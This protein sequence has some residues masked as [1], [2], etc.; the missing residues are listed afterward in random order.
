MENLEKLV[1]QAEE[2][3]YDTLESEY[4]GYDVFTDQKWVPVGSADMLSAAIEEAYIVIGDEET[5]SAVITAAYEALEAAINEFKAKMKDGLLPPGQSFNPVPVSGTVSGIPSSGTIKIYAEQAKTTLVKEVEVGWTVISHEFSTMEATVATNWTAQVPGQYTGQ[6]L[7]AEASYNGQSGAL[8]PVEVTETGAEGVSLTMNPVSPGSEIINLARLATRVKGVIN[9]FN[10]ITK[11]IEAANPV[12]NA[13]DGNLN[14]RMNTGT[15]SQSGE[16]ELT[17]A[18]PI[19]VNASVLRSYADDRINQYRV[20][21]LNASDVWET[22]YSH[23]GAYIPGSTTQGDVAVTNL[24]TAF[25]A[26]KVKLWFKTEGADKFPSI[27]EFELY[28]VADRTAI[29]A[30]IAAAKTNLASV[31]VSADG[32]DVVTGRQWVTEAAKTAYETAITTAQ[33]AAEVILATGADISAAQ[34]ALAAATSA[35]DAAKNTGTNDLDAE[36]LRAAYDAALA[37]LN[38]SFVQLANT[39]ASDYYADVRL[40]TQNNWNV[41]NGVIAGAESTLAAAEA[42]TPTATADQVNNA[43]SALESAAATFN[44]GITPGTKPLPTASVNLALLSDA[45]GPLVTVT[46]NSTTNGYPTSRL[47]DGDPA[48]DWRGGAPNYKAILTFAFRVPVTVNTMVIRDR[49]SGYIA[50]GAT[51]GA[52]FEYDGR[53]TIKAFSI[54]YIPVG[55]TEYA[56]AGRFVNPPPNQKRAI[57]YPVHMESFTRVTTRTLNM[58]IS[59]SL[60]TIQQI[61]E[62]GLYNGDPAELANDK[63]ALNT[64]IA[65]ATEECDEAAVAANGSNLFV[66]TPFV[67]TAQKTAFTAAIASARE[68]ADYPF[69]TVTEI[70]SAVTALTTAQ[71]AFNSGAGVGTRPLPTTPT[72]LARLSDAKGPLV[73][74]T[75]S[76]TT[77]GYPASR[78]IDGDITTDWRGSSSNYHGLITFTFRIPVAVNIMV[79]R[80]KANTL[81]ATTYPD[82]V[83]RGQLKDF[84]INYIPVA[85]TALTEAGRFENPPEGQSRAIAYPVHV[86][87]FTEVTTKTLNL[88]ISDSLAAIQQ[89]Y[90]IELYCGDVDAIS[91][92]DKT[93]LNALIIEAAEDNAAVTAAANGDDL[94]SNMYWVTTA[95]K[96][97][98]TAAIASAQEVA[99]NLFA[100]TADVDSAVTALTVAKTTFA[101]QK[102]PGTMVNISPQA[103]ATASN[104]HSDAYAPGK[105]ADGNLGS[106]WATTSSTRDCTLELT[107]AEAKTVSKA[108]VYSYADRITS[109]KIQYKDDNNDWQDAYDGTGVAITGTTTTPAAS[110]GRLYGFTAPVSSTAFRLNILAASAD[111][112][113]WEFALLQ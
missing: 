48:T 93:A 77:D 113:I 108:R 102:Q 95:Q 31:R 28:N 83:G 109:F 15:L 33:T 10:T 74:V 71:T 107:F 68:V 80:D 104:Q 78:L 72:N 111:P 112:S 55:G 61:Y 39:A 47:I 26:A 64:L 96:T 30:D 98:F 94:F 11:A 21:Y 35:F 89:I 5:D 81:N 73:T 6:T 60:A 25:T 27:W 46:A 32:T 52:A 84:T 12:T 59:D 106:R 34:T 50:D 66:G 8:V 3:V 40:V 1:E 54:N 24:F 44:A 67:T 53:G 90:E 103:T 92:T 22:A 101:G 14:S 70:A 19:T 36:G 105:A 88:N 4:D 79:I 97:A 85:G 41:F 13:V 49:A 75:A 87:T 57:A 37:S 7:Y 82:Y 76:G 58:D 38:T 100:T 17:F 29:L 2:L 56:E 20:Q 63:T 91:N 86:Q 110:G 51:S 69:A 9:E 18:S 23:S 99:G 45:K 42:A 65:E 62:I 43:I 16:I